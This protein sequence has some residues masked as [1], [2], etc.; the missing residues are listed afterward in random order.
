MRQPDFLLLD[1]F[2][3]ATR[4]DTTS[5][6]ELN[7]ISDELFKLRRAIRHDV[8]AGSLYLAYPLIRKWQGRK[9]LVYQL[10]RFTRKHD[11]AYQTA[12]RALEDRSTVV[13]QDACVAIGASMRPDGV[14]HLQ[15]MLHHGNSDVQLVARHALEELTAG[16]PRRWFI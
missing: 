3:L 8:I 4:L 2:I 12:I 7:A 13:I 9:T 6:A 1:A 5:W 14:H 15:R 10:S 11:K 16:K